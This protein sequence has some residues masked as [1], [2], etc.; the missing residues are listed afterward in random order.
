MKIK[1]GSNFPPDCPA[2]SKTQTTFLAPPVVP[3][4]GPSP[5]GTTV[6]LVLLL[7]LSPVGHAQGDA[8]RDCIWESSRVGIFA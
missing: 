8:T 6:L 3:R 4:S 7:F 5:L 2:F 1:A